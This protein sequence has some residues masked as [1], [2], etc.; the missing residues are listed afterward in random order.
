MKKLINISFIYFIFAMI[1]GVFYR[2]FTKLFNFTGKTTLAF[3]HL[4]LI[5]LGT[6]LFLILA[7]FSINTDLLNQKKFNTFL[8]F[9]NISLPLMVII[10]V[11][12]G[13]LQVLNANL[14]SGLNAAISG[15]SGIS[16]IL[17]LISFILLFSILKNLNVDKNNMK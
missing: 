12:R 4:H 1:G 3:I 8:K 14:S 5:A 17:M 7:L 11:I 2:E 16:H 13:I 9:Y 10:M 6:I 15:I